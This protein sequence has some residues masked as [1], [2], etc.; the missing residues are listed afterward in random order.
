MRLDWCGRDY[1]NWREGVNNERCG[2]VLV[3]SILCAT[4][5]YSAPLRLN[6]PGIANVEGAEVA[7]RKFQTR[8]TSRNESPYSIRHCRPRLGRGF[9]PDN[10][11]SSD[12]Y[13]ERIRSSALVFGLQVPA[14][15]SYPPDLED[16]AQLRRPPTLRNNPDGTNPNTTAIRSRR[17]RTNQIRL[18]GKP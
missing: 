11:N 4:S 3:P 6:S 7:Q 16:C 5:A 8:E 17:R 18:Q 10:V 1:I 12:R 9:Q 13:K 14:D 2:S 15:R